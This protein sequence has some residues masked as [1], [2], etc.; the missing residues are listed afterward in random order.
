[1]KNTFIH[2]AKSA[3]TAF[4]FFN[5]STCHKAFRGEARKGRK[6]VTSFFKRCSVFPKKM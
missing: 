1:M 5:E 4:T 3:F 2:A 6:D